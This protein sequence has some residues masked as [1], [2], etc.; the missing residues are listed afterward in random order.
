VGRPARRRAEGRRRQGRREGKSEGGRREGRGRR[1]GW[2]ST[3]ARGRGTS[4]RIP[5]IGRGQA[6]VGGGERAAESR[7][8]IC[9]RCPAGRQC[10]WCQRCRR[11]RRCSPPTA[12]FSSSLPLGVRPKGGSRRMYTSPRLLPSVS[13]SCPSSRPTSCSQLPAPSSRLLAPGHRSGGEGPTRI[14]QRVALGGDHGDFDLGEADCHSTDHFRALPRHPAHSWH[15]HWQCSLDDADRACGCFLLCS[16]A[17]LHLCT[18]ALV[19]LCSCALVLLCPCR[20]SE[21]G[22]SPEPGERVSM[23]GSAGQVWPRTGWTWIWT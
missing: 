12:S 21:R 23:V 14:G 10:R 5:F 13:G 16:P 1:W 11:C 20:T 6:L 18:C 17:L 19:L 9:Q 8:Q 22:E 2:S 7:Q 4:L 15:C 3:V